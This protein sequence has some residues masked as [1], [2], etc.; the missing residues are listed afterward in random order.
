MCVIILFETEV[1]REIIDMFFTDEAISQQL[2]I[3][4]ATRKIF[5]FDL[6]GTIIY[7]GLRMEDRFDN[8]LQSIVAAGHRVY[9]AT[10]R[11]YR[12]FIPMVP[13]WSRELPSVVFGGG[14]VINDKKILHQRHLPS[15]ELAELIKTLD[16]QKVPFLLDGADNYFHSKADSWI[17]E[18]I[19]RIS[20]QKPIHNVDN[21]LS[22]GAYKILVLDL[23][24]REYCAN[25][26]K[27]YGWELKYHSYNNCFDLMPKGVNKFVGIQYLPL[28]DQDNIFI[29]GNDHNDLELMQNYHN[30]IMFGD[31]HELIQYAKIKIDYDDNLFE[32]FQQVVNVILKK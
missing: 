24:W 9:F 29:F 18:D 32:K 1:I 11:S 13:V 19:L 27:D 4:P 5:V 23:N 20:G 28:V 25:V 17:L 16:H 30:S 10:G 6:D 2:K 7:N 8:V 15:P 3:N 14:L 22:D 21:I 31:Y 26:A 12:D